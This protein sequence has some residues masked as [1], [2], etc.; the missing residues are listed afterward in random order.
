MRRLAFGLALVVT[1]GLLGLAVVAGWGFAEF[2]RIGPSTVPVTV[3]V[4]PG[5]GV[6]AI[7]RGLA[8][9]GAV[10]DARL[11]E[12]TARLSGLGRRLQAGEYRLPARASLA[13]I[14]RQLAAGRTIVRR[15]TVPEGLTS[16]EIGRLLGRVAGLAG[17]PGALPGEGRLLPETY[18][19]AYGDGRADLV[20]RM[21]AAMTETLAELWPA[22]RRGLPLR[23]PEEAVILAS[24]VE[25]E[26]ALASERPR[27]AAVFINRLRRGMRLQSDPTVVYALTRGE[28]PLDRPLTRADLK[29]AS[30]YN[31]YLHDGL[32]PGP[33]ANPGRASLAAVLNPAETRDLYFVADGSGGHAFAETLAEHN[34]NA[35]RW[36]RLERRHEKSDQGG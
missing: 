34:R 33:I 16:A 20:R 2:R 6:A 32:P 9:A 25:K 22:R 8:R 7:G 12:V 35:A 23:S 29:I 15:V 27:I 10:R 21:A 26:T 5:Q 3:I 31:T 18:H 1:L 19:F 11:F 30:P 14:L 17:D 36:R 24:I 13:E 4:E 28:G